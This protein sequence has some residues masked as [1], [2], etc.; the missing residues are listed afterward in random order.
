MAKKKER[1]VQQE[2][3]KGRVSS[4]KYQLHSIDGYGWR[5][6]DGCSLG[7]DSNSHPYDGLD[8]PFV[9][10]GLLV[11]GVVDCILRRRIVGGI[12]GGIL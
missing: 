8:V 9:G 2:K 3:E 6:D 7:V 4:P 1:I 11:D 5:I 12:H 10:I